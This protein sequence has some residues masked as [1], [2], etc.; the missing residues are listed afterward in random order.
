MNGDCQICE[1]KLELA[2]TDMSCI[3]NNP[4]T[5]NN[6]ASACLQTLYTLGINREHLL[7]S[8]E[9]HTT[10][11][12]LR[13]IFV[14]RNMNAIVK[15]NCRVAKDALG[16]SAGFADNEALDSIVKGLKVSY[17]P[18]IDITSYLDF[19][20]G[21]TTRAVREIIRKL[22]EEPYAMK[23]SERLN[24]KLVDLNKEI[25]EIGKSRS[26]KFYQAVSD[27][28]VY[29]GSKFLENNSGALIKVQKKQLH[30]TSEWIASKLL[31]IHAKA[32]GKDWTLAQIYK[33]RTKF[34]KYEAAVKKGEATS[35]P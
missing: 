8:H 11:C 23:Y 25:E 21:K 29:G 32:T 22:K 31:D 35:N 6:C 26:A 16:V 12:A 13:D 27:I 18:E 24:G 2:K 14:S 30:K 10:V 20:D 33:T 9:P 3:N 5:Q 7:K 15:T 34:E 1:K 17:S 19:L 28:A 4:E